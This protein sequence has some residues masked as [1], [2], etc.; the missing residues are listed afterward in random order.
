MYGSRE[1]K[2]VLRVRSHLAPLWPLLGVL[3]EII[4]LVIIIVVYEKR[5]KPEDLQDGESAQVERG[6]IFL[7]VCVLGQCGAG[8]T[9][10]SA[11]PALNNSARRGR[12]CRHTQ[13]VTPRQDTRIPLKLMRHMM[14][15][16]RGGGK[17]EAF[18]LRPAGP[19]SRDGLQPP[20]NYAA[21]PFW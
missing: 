12:P 17:V 13:E 9:Q 3:A 7:P 15:P 14:R 8:V 5:K 16:C 20:L 18:L 21:T 10:H 11:T 4:I 2:S 19:A 1:E 6:F